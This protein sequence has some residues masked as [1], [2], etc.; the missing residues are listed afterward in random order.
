MVPIEVEN[1]PDRQRDLE[2]SNA[3][4]KQTVPDWEHA[5]K[6]AHHLEDRDRNVKDGRS[7]GDEQEPEQPPPMLHHTHHADGN[8][9][10][11]AH[12]GQRG[13]G[14]VAIRWVEAEHEQ[15]RVDEGA[16]R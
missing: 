10:Q 3:H 9:E 6:G 7:K 14:R 8:H 2:Q 13:W 15:V 4:P 11:D 1:H 12:Q 5:W 16:A